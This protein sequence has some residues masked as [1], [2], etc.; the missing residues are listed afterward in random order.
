M[1]NSIR[2]EKQMLCASKRTYQSG[3]K[4]ADTK[5]MQRASSYP[6]LEDDQSFRVEKCLG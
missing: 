1:S 5:N 3:G 6:A 2:S 4:P